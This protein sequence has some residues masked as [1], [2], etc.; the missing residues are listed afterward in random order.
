[1]TALAKKEESDSMN[2]WDVGGERGTYTSPF[3]SAVT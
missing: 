1:M 2:P 3:K